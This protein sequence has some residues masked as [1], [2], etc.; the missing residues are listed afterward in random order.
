[1]PGVE[2]VELLAGGAESVV[3]AVEAAA[4]L[5]IASLFAVEAIVFVA[6]SV[7]LVEQRLGAVG[8]FVERG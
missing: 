5:L 3:V 7:A 6:E 2:G 4:E 1:L 8:E